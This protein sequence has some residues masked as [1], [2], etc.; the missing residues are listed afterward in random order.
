MTRITKGPD[1]AGHRARRRAR[2][3]DHPGR[4]GRGA[5]MSS[6]PGETPEPWPP[7]T[8][9][10]RASA[11]ETVDLTDEASIAALRRTARHPGPRG[12]HRLGSG[13]RAGAGP[14]S[15][16]DPAVLRHQGDRAAHAGQ[17]SGP[18][19]EH[20]RLVRAVL[21][22]GRG[23]IAVGTLGV[24]IT[25]A[26]ADTLARSLALELAPIRVTAISPG[27]NRH[28]RLGRPSAS[29]ARPAT[30]PA[31]SARN[32]ASASAPPTTLPKASCSP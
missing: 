31:I 27:V 8:P 20:R 6:A 21:R 29:R 32:P 11:T 16:R 24:A 10:S 5:R 19:D 9:A 28:R 12:V 22:R 30:S 4:P 13:P 2:L 14:G 18:P 15:G 25:N 26:A 3:R 1:R 23:Q 7:P 17:A